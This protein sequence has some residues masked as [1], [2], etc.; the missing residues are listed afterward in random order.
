MI[1]N[2][3]IALQGWLPNGWVG[4]ALERKNAPL[5]ANYRKGRQGVACVFA[6][7]ALLEGLGSTV[8]WCVVAVNKLAVLQVIP[9]K[10][11]KI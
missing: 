4:L 6:E 11:L 9:L 5:F 3:K 8:I 2:L 10:K 1:D 7:Y